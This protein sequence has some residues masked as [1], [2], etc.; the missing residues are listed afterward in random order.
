MIPYKL[1]VQVI[2]EH[3]AYSMLYGAKN[4]A[5][6]FNISE[7]L[8]YEGIRT[9]KRF[10]SDQYKEL[11]EECKRKLEEF[12]DEY[13][14]EVAIYSF[15]NG[16]AKAKTKYRISSISLWYFRSFLFKHLGDELDEIILKIISNAGKEG[17]TCSKILTSLKFYSCS[18]NGKV[19]ESPCGGNVLEPTLNKLCLQGLIERKGGGGRY[20]LADPEKND[21]PE[22]PK[23][24]ETLFYKQEIE[25]LKD[26]LLKLLLKEAGL[27]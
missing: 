27:D 23:G 1:N 18:C 3:V 7:N 19:L 14:K 20:I 15:N 6:H 5:I 9:L 17:A 10:F 22:P 12:P 24:E 25:K 26:L 8:I 21:V 4:A 11:E 16:I 2:K 13:K